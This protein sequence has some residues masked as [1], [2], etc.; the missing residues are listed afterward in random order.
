[1]FETPTVTDVFSCPHTRLLELALD[2]A[3][4]E[5]FPLKSV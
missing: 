5:Y 1:V 3:I 2:F 4:I